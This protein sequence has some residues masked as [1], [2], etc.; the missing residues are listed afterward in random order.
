MTVDR[1][2]RDQPQRRVPVVSVVGDA[3]LA[4]DADRAVAQALGHALMDAGF[5][6]VTGGMGGVMAAVSEGARASSAW[7]E[8]RIIGILPSYKGAESNAFC[9]IVIPTGLQLGR[10]VL[11]VAAADVVLAIGGG[12]GTLSELALAWQLG[13]PIVVLGQRGWAGRVAGE[14]LDGRSD[15]P[16]HAADSVAN[17]VDAC[18]GAVQLLVEPGEIGSGWRAPLATREPAT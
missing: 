11:V 2:D 10:N 8:G 14:C 9:D 15:Q 18:V 5:R 6:L 7:R 16:I 12:A 13:K 4:G 1:T 17:A 3:S